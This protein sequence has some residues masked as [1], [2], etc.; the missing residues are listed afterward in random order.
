MMTS[1]SAQPG[2]LCFSLFVILVITMFQSSKRIAQLLSIVLAISGCSVRVGIGP[3]PTAAP[4]VKNP[5]DTSNWQPIFVDDFDRADT[6]AAWNVLIGQW[7]LENGTLKGVL[8]RD[9][10]ASG[11]FHQAS[12]KLASVDLPESV[13]IAYD[14]WSP[15]E[16]GSE[17]KLLND[18]GTRGVI[19][20]LYATP[21]PAINARCAALLVQ[22]TAGQFDFVAVNHSYVPNLKSKRSV[23]IVRQ[24]EGITVYV[25]GTQ[26]VS[27]GLTDP[28]AREGTLRL[29]GTFGGEGSVV[30]FDRL[31]IRAPS[32][33]KLPG[34]ETAKQQSN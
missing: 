24:P 15:D 21:H 25:D 6:G 11:N 30:Y 34:S 9:S 23:R 22:K 4:P 19:A 1:S 28:T 17:A 31:S 20:A 13:E 32:S 8:T 10:S 2:A 18:S 14:T 27:A 16:V 26:V 5:A 12:I 29:V 7:S 3:T 33:K